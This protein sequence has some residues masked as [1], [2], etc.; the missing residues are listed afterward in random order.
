MRVLLRTRGAIGPGWLALGYRGALWTD[1]V[2]AQ[3]HLRGP[4][5]RGT[6]AVRPRVDGGDRGAEVGLQSRTAVVRE[7]RRTVLG[8]DRAERP[9]VARADDDG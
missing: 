5:A 7:R 6:T 2:M 4:R 8:L 9:D 1:F 3:S